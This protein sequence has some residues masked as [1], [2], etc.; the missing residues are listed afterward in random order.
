MLELAHLRD[1]TCCLILFK[2]YIQKLVSTFYT[3]YQNRT[4][5]VQ[6]SIKMKYIN[7]LMNC[8]I[9]KILPVRREILQYRV[10]LSKHRKDDTNKVQTNAFWIDTILS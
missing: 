10:D 8:L 5:S 9:F 1:S 2:H 7:T 4:L 3:Q 6:L